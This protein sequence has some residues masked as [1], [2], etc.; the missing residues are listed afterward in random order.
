M[1]VVDVSVFVK[2]R[3][4]SASYVD[5]SKQSGRQTSKTGRRFM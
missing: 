3:P 5:E 2:K 4:G 1:E